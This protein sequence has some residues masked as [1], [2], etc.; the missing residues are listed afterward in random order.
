MKLKNINETIEKNEDNILR[1]VNKNY[2]IKVVELARVF[3]VTRQTIYYYFKKTNEEFPR[4]FKET[5]KTIYGEY[6]FDRALKI[7]YI[8]RNSLKLREE[9]FTEMKR[10]KI[11]FNRVENKN[12]IYFRLKKTPLSEA[13]E[14]KDK[15][16]EKNIWLT[17]IKLNKNK[18]K[19]PLDIYVLMEEYYHKNSPEYTRKIFLNLIKNKKDDYDVSKY[20]EQKT[21]EV[22]FGK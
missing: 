1:Y 17:A 6:D 13:I 18:H 5:I 14:L 15:F 10:K 22:R 2:G 8:N 4:Q 12:R 11:K 3:N 21:K 9:M 20:L 7:N 16:D 19:I